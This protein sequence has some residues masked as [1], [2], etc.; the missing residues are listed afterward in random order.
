MNCSMNCISNWIAKITL[1]DYAINQFKDL[2]I[3][4]TLIDDNNP[5]SEDLSLNPSEGIKVKIGATDKRKPV[6]LDISNDSGAYHGLICGT[7]GSGKSVLLHQ[8]ITAGV[9]QYTPNE[10]QFVLLDYK[11]GTGFKVYKD[12]PHA[13]II[14]IDADIDFGYE[15]FKF[16]T[17]EMKERAKL[18]KKYDT[19]DIKTIQRK[20]KE[21]LPKNISNC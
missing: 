1:P 13:R 17:N 10:L 15:S 8:I 11:E 18:F 16:L 4:N 21:R 6:Y 7:T 19:K 12:L 3:S 5:I 2:S 9:K 20:N 14:A